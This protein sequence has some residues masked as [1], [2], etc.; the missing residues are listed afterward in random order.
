MRGVTG[1]AGGVPCVCLR[2]SR[3]SFPTGLH[4]S[5]PGVAWSG[6]KSRVLA[7][8]SICEEATTSFRLWFS[9]LHQL[10]EFLLQDVRCK[11]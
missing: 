7:D 5:H 8:L 4:G 2:A 10:Y 11:G 1:K 9:H 6:F 3:S